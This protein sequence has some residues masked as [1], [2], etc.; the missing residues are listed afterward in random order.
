MI[1]TPAR[2]DSP[3]RREGWRR[4][5]ARAVVF[6]A[7]SFSVTSFLLGD[8]VYGSGSALLAAG[9]AAG[10]YRTRGSDPVSLT[11]ESDRRALGAAILIVGFGPG[12]YAM[13]RLP[14]FP[15][16]NTFF[17][18]AATA[19]V[20]A[21]VA[22]CLPRGSARRRLFRLSRVLGIVATL[23]VMVA[24]L[25]QAD[26]DG[27]L[28]V[29]ASTV[30]TIVL[31][32]QTGLALWIVRGSPR[33]EQRPLGVTY[34][35]LVLTSAVLAVLG[36]RLP[37]VVVVLAVALVAVR[38]ALWPDALVRE[39]RPLRPLDVALF[40]WVTL[41]V[42]VGTETLQR[43]NGV[44][45]GVAALGAGCLLMGTMSSGPRFHRVVL[46]AVAGIAGAAAVALLFVLIPS[47]ASTRWL[48]DQVFYAPSRFELR[49]ER[50]SAS[51]RE[52]WFDTTQT[53]TAALVDAHLGLGS[54]VSEWK[55]TLGNDIDAHVFAYRLDVRVWPALA[56]APDR[57]PHPACRNE[58]RTCV[59]V[60]LRR[61]DD[62]EAD[63]PFRPLR[64]PTVDPG[65][66]S[67]RYG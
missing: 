24:N 59:L 55:G 67:P 30:T 61:S 33:Q 23:A 9:V 57:R 50:S 65:E 44:A 52:L 10:L 4:P 37:T 36:A 34:V 31:L 13:R 8:P 15:L 22:I 19:L 32:V 35:A 42:L 39:R 53:P 62:R 16:Q 5:V 49:A 1:A 26:A 60:V 38:F 21:G 51:R 11:P 3:V 25:A 28:D 27:S 63:L 66:L 2:S 40:V 47:K 29:R 56:S 18:A 20:V 46:S 54:F 58:T 6:V 64:L 7:A 48:M 12:L 45:V 41:V 17:F 43:S 14:I